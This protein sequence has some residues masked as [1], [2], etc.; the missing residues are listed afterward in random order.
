LALIWLAM[1]VSELLYYRLRKLQW[2]I[3]CMR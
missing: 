1:P 2:K 3:D